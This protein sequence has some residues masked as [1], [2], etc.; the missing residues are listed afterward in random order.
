MERRARSL[1]KKG[2][3][4][5]LFTIME[6]S[7]RAR[8]TSGVV[9][10]AL[11]H[12]DALTHRLLEEAITAAGIGIASACNVLDVEAVVIGGGLGTRLGAP[13]VRAVDASMHPHLL[14]DGED[15]V[16]VV[17]AGLSDDS[18][19]LGAATEAAGLVGTPAGA[20]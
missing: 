17:P 20:G 3:K 1:V 11:E 13:F 14:V 6:K 18:G 4:T 15:A 2:R 9:A 10:R 19:A 7:G 12:G 16:K 5:E 8:V